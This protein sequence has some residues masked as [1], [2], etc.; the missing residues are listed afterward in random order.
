MHIHSPFSTGQ[1]IGRPGPAHV[2]VG[3][4]RTEPVSRGPRCHVMGRA[5]PGQD[6]WKCDG[7]GRA[8]AHPLKF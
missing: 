3:P 1:H 8:A 4:A 2:I 5:R 6:F 7:L